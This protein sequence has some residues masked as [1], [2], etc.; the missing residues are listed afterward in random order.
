MY[1]ETLNSLD[2]IF[3][4]AQRHG[5]Q[6]AIVALDAALGGTLSEEVYQEA[7]KLQSNHDYLFRLYSQTISQTGGFH[8]AGYIAESEKA[9]TNMEKGVSLF[10]KLLQEADLTRGLDQSFV[11]WIRINDNAHHAV[12]LIN[13]PGESIVSVD[14][15]RPYWVQITKPN[16]A[17]QIFTRALSEN[18]VW[19][20]NTRVQEKI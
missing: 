15:N 10:T 16:Q 14:T 7:N 6:C 9:V 2:N 8:R 1:Q 19:W 4:K 3:C 17:S 18:C 20:I 11:C 13:G 12:A 5:G